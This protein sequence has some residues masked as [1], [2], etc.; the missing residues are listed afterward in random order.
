[1]GHFAI[2]RTFDEC[3]QSITSKNCK[4]W[5]EFEVG[6]SYL[7]SSEI[8]LYLQNQFL[9]LTDCVDSGTKTLEFESVQSEFESLGIS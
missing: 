8:N 3:T 5:A 9:I 6:F 2:L 4:Q 1:M 7:K